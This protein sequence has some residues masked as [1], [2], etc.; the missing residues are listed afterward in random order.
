M[1][2]VNSVAFYSLVVLMIV[3]KTWVSGNYAILSC[4]GKR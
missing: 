1:E 4:F 2:K 3:R